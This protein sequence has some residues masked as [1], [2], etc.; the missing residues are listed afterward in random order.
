MFGHLAESLR[1]YRWPQLQP[2]SNKEQGAPTGPCSDRNQQGGNG[3]LAAFFRYHD[4]RVEPNSLEILSASVGHSRE[5]HVGFGNH[6]FSILACSAQNFSID[7]NGT[8]L[9]LMR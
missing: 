2:I 7:L 8:R 3:R 9:P 5:K 4:I 6:A 1:L